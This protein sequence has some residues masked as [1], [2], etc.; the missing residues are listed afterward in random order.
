MT[1]D[2]ITLSIHGMPPESYFVNNK[3]CNIAVFHGI[4]T[5]FM[6]ECEEILGVGVI[7]LSIIIDYS[8][9]YRQFIYHFHQYI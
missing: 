3:M 5:I 4:N 2:L 6:S 9:R 1:I 8:N 7:F